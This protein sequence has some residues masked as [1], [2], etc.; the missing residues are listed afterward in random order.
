M[1]TYEFM[2]RKCGVKVESQ[3]SEPPAC[4]E[5]GSSL[6]R[7]YFVPAVIFKGDGFYSTENRRGREEEKK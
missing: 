1:P 5:C 6:Y 3:R 7:V 2:C 4:P